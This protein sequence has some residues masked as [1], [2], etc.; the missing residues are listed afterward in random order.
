MSKRYKSLNSDKASK[1]SPKRDSSRALFD[2]LREARLNRHLS[3]QE[4]ARKLGL[5]QRQISDLER[6]S[7]D[8][9]LSTVQNVARAL[10]LELLLVPRHLI[11]AIEGLQRVG[12][13]ST[14]RPMYALTDDDDD[15][16]ADRDSQSPTEL[17]S[18]AAP[19][20]QQ[21]RRAPKEPR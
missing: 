3:Q 13:E 12:T 10:D 18:D 6:A 1:I 15:D 7:M 9:R 11:P 17:G 16:D 8:P 2:I 20:D 14:N 21:T 5:R 4:V 19:E